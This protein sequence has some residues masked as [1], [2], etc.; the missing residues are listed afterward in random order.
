MLSPSVTCEMLIPLLWDIC[1]IQGSL[2]W[3]LAWALPPP[4]VPTVSQVP[5]LREHP[6]ARTCTPNPACPQLPK[7]PFGSHL[8]PSSRSTSGQGRNGQN[9]NRA[10][11]ES[12]GSD[13]ARLEPIIN[14]QRRSIR[15]AAVL[16]PGTRTGLGP[17]LP[18]RESVESLSGTLCHLNAGSL[19]PSRILRGGGGWEMHLYGLSRVPR[20]TSPPPG[21]G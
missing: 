2:C 6:L 15:A 3:L 10:F 4:S 11:A 16:Q 14:K 7:F 18:P 8:L 1:A 17:L 9:H 19:L 12:R 5:P 20:G 21:Q 13:Q